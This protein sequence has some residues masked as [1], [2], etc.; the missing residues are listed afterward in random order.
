MTDESKKP[1]G[2]ETVAAARQEKLHNLL[3]FA[4]PQHTLFARLRTLRRGRINRLRPDQAQRLE[5]AVLRCAVAQGRFG[6]CAPARG[7]WEDC[8][9]AVGIECR[10]GLVNEEA[11]T[12]AT[13]RRRHPAHQ[14]L[15]RR[16]PTNS[17]QR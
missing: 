2:N 10:P 8:R 17:P 5:Q 15:Y 6:V 12:E 7:L 16:R 9:C 1:S 14:V 13:R 11:L 4:W 3:S